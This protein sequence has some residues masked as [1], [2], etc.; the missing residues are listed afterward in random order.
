MPIDT[1]PRIRVNTWL[2]TCN[3][4]KFDLGAF[5]HDGQELHSWS[6]AR[7]R[8]ELA[9]GDHFA[10]WVTGDKGGLIARGRITGPPTRELSTDIDYWRE[11]P[12]PRWYVPL[13]VDEW[14]DE[15]IP[16]SQFTVDSR[17][18]GKPP[19][20]FLRA[21]N[22]H[23]LNAPQWEAFTTSFVRNEAEGEPVGSL[24]G[25]PRLPIGCQYRPAS[26]TV[27]LSVSPPNLP[28]PHLVERSLKSHRKLQNDLAAAAK[29][30][31]MAVRSPL[32]EEN[33]PEFDVAWFNSKGVLTVCEVK[34]LTNENEIRQLRAGIGQLLDYHDQLRNEA[35]EVRAV[36]W[37]EREPSESRWLALCTRIGI[38]LA[39][40][41]CE[42][43]VIR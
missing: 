24:P 26:E 2:L 5:R 37:V 25:A 9:K 30:R 34:S 14:L 11:D 31:G 21:G 22:P 28:D 20:D 42:D 16:R 19:L 4:N 1:K 38:K 40:P 27:A 32:V 12:G 15:P 18:A 6:V 23:P 13:V 10:L 3:P 43:A 29:K 8:G 36:L 41:G 17:F 35:M 33:E 7:Y 39:W